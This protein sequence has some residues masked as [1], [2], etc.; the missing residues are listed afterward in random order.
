MPEYIFHR[1][2]CADAAKSFIKLDCLRVAF[3]HPQVSGLVTLP[4]YV[5]GCRHHQSCANAFGPFGR[6][7]MKIFD[8]WMRSAPNR[9]EAND[10][11]FFGNQNDILRLDLHLMPMVLKVF[12]KLAGQIRLG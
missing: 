12:G 2:R 10:A 6:F 8:I 9:Y 3:H 7:H 4:D 5:L 11:F 1:V